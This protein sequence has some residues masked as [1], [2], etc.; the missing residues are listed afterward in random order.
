MPTFRELQ[1]LVVAVKGLSANERLAL[2]HCEQGCTAQYKGMKATEQLPAG[3]SNIAT[4]HVVKASLR[5]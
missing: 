3:C 4:K 2:F 5:H 1:D